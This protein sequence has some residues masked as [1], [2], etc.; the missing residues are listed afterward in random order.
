MFEG[1]F[2]S[3]SGDLTNHGRTMEPAKAIKENRT[4]AKEPFLAI[5]PN[6][7]VDVFSSSAVLGSCR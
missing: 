1:G 5:S 3:S 2:S 7:S 4:R 6:T